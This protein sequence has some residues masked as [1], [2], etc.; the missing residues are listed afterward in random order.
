V[1]NT[2]PDSGT[3]IVHRKIDPWQRGPRGIQFNPASGGKM[4]PL[5]EM[6]RSFD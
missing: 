1:E 3:E 6:Q 2:R 4:Q 5:F